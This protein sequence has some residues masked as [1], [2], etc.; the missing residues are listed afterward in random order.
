MRHDPDIVDQYHAGCTDLIKAIPA[1]TPIISELL[2]DAPGNGALSG[3]TEE[4]IAFVIAVTARYDDHM[5]YRSQVAIKPELSRPEAI[6]II[7]VEFLMEGGPL[8]LCDVEIAG[9]DDTFSSMRQWN[10]A[11]RVWMCF[12]IRNPIEL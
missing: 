12:E 1:A 10:L 11:A 3:Q 8:M 6:E 7:D 5:V 9:I 4:L 2:N